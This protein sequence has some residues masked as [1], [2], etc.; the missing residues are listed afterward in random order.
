MPIQKV[1]KEFIIK[2]AYLLFREKGYHKTSMADV[3]PV[4]GLLKGSEYY[5]FPSKDEL[6]LQVLHGRGEES[7]TELFFRAG[8]SSL[9]INVKI[10]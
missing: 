9:K 4:C 1:D 2:K 3:G 10:I 7:F 8:S 5:C 6:L